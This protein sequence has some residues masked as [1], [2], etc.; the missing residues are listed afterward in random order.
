[1][2][3]DFGQALEVGAYMSALRRT[4]IGDFDIANAITWED[5][6]DEVEVL[7]GNEANVTNDSNDA[8]QKVE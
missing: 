8:F 7:L 6:R 5:L 1:L 4:K 3:N 2:V